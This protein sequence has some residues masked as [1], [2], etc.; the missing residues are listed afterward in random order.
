MRFNLVWESDIPNL[1]ESEKLLVARELVYM[2]QVTDDPSTMIFHH[3]FLTDDM[4]GKTIIAYG[5]E[6]NKEDIF[7]EYF[8]KPD[9]VSLEEFDLE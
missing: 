8:E 7:L 4:D 5:K 9:W 1:T 3:I 2:E 6:G